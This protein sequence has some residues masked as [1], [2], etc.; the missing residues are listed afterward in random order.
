[1]F[2]LPGA[3]PSHLVFLLGK[4][5]TAYLEDAN[6][7]GGISAPVASILAGSTLVINATSL[8]TTATATYVAYRAGGEYCTG[9]NTGTDL[10]TL[11]IIPGSPP[12]FQGSWCAVATGGGSTIVTTTDGH[13]DAIVWAVGSTGNDLLQGF[14]GDTGATI[15]AGGGAP[16]TGS[17][18]YNAPIA[19][20]GRI[21]VSADG[22]VAAFTP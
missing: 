17:R 3:L 8:Y 9:G 1:V 6:N 19:A 13:N 11:K 12:R 4:S 22:A 2:D 7:L 21:F 15:F 14:D 20:K 18:R 5:G 16:I 10:A